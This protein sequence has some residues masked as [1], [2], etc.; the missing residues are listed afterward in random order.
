MNMRQRAILVAAI[1]LVAVM[2]L[3]PPWYTAGGEDGAHRFHRGYRFIND[4]PAGRSRIEYTRYLAGIA[5]VCFV[6]AL[7]FFETQDR[8][9]STD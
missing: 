8:R 2:L 6:A 4:P 1:A 5:L 9:L 7:G 3:F